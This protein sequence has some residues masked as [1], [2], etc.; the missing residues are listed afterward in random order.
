MPNCTSFTLATS[1]GE[2]G[3]LASIS[4]H[5]AAAPVEAAPSF[6]S[7]ASHCL[8]HAQLFSAKIDLEWDRSDRGLRLLREMGGELGSDSGE[9]A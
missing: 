9:S 4:P 3:N 1:A 7:A 2:Y 6:G 8:E 5:G